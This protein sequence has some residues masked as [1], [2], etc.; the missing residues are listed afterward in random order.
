MVS[1]AVSNPNS[2]QPQVVI[3]VS[4]FSCVRIQNQGYIVLVSFVDR[5]VPFRRSLH[6]WD[7]FLCTGIVRLLPVG[8]LRATVP[9]RSLRPP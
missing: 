5:S 3:V 7:T 6:E 9:I 1:A 2:T 4:M 8:V